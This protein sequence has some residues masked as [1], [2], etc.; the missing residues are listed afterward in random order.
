MI[1]LIYLILLAAA[2]LFWPLYRDDLSFL[3]L[4]TLIILPFVLLLQLA[5]SAA[6][7]K[8]SLMAEDITVFKDSEGELGIKLSNR[9]VFPL[10][11]VKIRIL[12]RFLPTGEEAHSTACV[13]LPSLRT[14]TVTV[15]V[16]AEHCGAAELTVEYVKI[17]DLLGLFSVKICRNKLKARVHIVPKISESFAELA[18]Y[19][20]SMGSL[21]YSSDSS[22]RADRINPGDVCGFREFAPGDRLSLIHYKLSARF[23]SDIVKVLGGASCGRYLL[24]ADMSGDKMTELS[25]RDEIL[26]KIMSC[27]Y[28]MNAGGG[29]V[30]AAVPLDSSCDGIYTDGLLAAK[31][32][33]DSSYFPIAR[34]LCESCYEGASAAGGF[35]LCQMGKE[36]E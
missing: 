35:I 21:E 5:I 26:Q 15:N 30:Y 11:N 19:Y 3:T 12:S 27:A 9:S 34:A 33:D 36:D 25:Q 13:P 18:Q 14:E 23:D 4:V 2:A 7:F 32:F 17:S 6:F 10:S 1:K 28:Y 29:E 31:Y 16:G 20:L 22:D 24:T 8:C